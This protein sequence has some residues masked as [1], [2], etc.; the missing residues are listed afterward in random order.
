M[1]RVQAGDPGRLWIVAAQQGAGRGRLARPWASPPG[2]LYA[3]IVL[4]GDVEPARAAELGFVAG[5]ALVE[6]LA[7]MLPVD[8]APRLKWPN[9]LLAGGGK[10]AGILLE[11]SVLA[12]GR[13]ACVVGCGVNCASHPQPTAYPAASLA[14][15]GG[16]GVPE[17]VFAALSAAFAASFD[18]WRGAGGFA[19]IRSRWLAAGH[20]PGEQI[21]VLRG[22][23]RTTG[24]FRT[25]DETGRLVLATADGE[26]TIDT[27]DVML[28]Q[29][30]VG[31]GTRP[32]ATAKAE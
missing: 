23:Q 12:D 24:A 31:A 13:F 32:M 19:A 21:A 9:D 14:A 3:S 20:R 28:P 29:V 15:L 30:A 5:V 27:G 25:I 10:L 11:G 18:I 8:C 22:E 16:P 2:N 6:A 7:P 26:T 17:P 1:R 4:V